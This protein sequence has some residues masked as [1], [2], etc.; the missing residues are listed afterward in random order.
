MNGDAHGNSPT[1]G[2]MRRP[3][4]PAV[5]AALIAVAGCTP[6]T[7]TAVRPAEHAG[8]PATRLH[9]DVPT[10]TRAAPV[11]LRDAETARA[12]VTVE[13]APPP[14]EP[15]PHRPP[16]GGH[17]P[18]EHPPIPV[19]LDV[20]GSDQL[21]DGQPTAR[22]WEPD[23][24]EAAAAEVLKRRFEVQGLTVLDLDVRPASRDENARRDDDGRGGAGT[25]LKVVV[26]HTS[27]HSHPH[28]SIYLATLVDDG[29]GWQIV[30]VQALP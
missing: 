13:A 22:R 10:G 30:D 11:T 18:R 26:V 16:T 24:P 29:D 9:V 14:P 27:G 2:S 6:T 7:T 19:E 23:G 8:S 20:T 28:Q 1:G 25:R 21:H 15:T 5:A 4:L 3:T 17:P 12:V